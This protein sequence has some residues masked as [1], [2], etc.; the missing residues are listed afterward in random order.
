MWLVMVLCWSLSILSEISR[1]S[2]EPQW[3][4]MVW[5]SWCNRLMATSKCSPC[6]PQSLHLMQAFG[7]CS[8]ILFQDNIMTS[9]ITTDI[10]IY[11]TLK[12]L[13]GWVKLT[14]CSPS[15]QS[16]VII[17]FVDSHI[18]GFPLVEVESNWVGGQFQTPEEI[19]CLRNTISYKSKVISKVWISDLDSRSIFKGRII[20]NGNISYINNNM[21]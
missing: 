1:D 7:N 11:Q 16:R 19:L 18:L 2:R 6:S 4:G 8:R 21:V 15:N 9:W 5:P 14:Q 20:Q 17:S 10:S 12:C 3:G 13:T